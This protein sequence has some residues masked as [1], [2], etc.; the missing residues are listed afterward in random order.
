MCSR[1]KPSLLRQCQP[2]KNNTSVLH[3]Y[4][5]TIHMQRDSSN[6]IGIYLEQ[7]WRNKHLYFI[8]CLVC[9]WILK[10]RRDRTSQLIE[11]IMLL[12]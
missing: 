7:N 4:F 9:V 8:S 12:H 10:E 5:I 1:K 3:C 11:P 6:S 2:G